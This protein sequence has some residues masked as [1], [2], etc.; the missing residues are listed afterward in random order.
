MGKNY[1]ICTLGHGIELRAFMVR[2]MARSMHNMWPYI[3]K[4]LRLL[5]QE[6]IPVNYQVIL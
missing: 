3:G 4:E 2:K 1:V 6:D 5:P